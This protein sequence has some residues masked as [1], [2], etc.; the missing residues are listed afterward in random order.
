MK[1][2]NHPTAQVGAPPHHNSDSR[3]A[4]TDN[5]EEV[6]REICENNKEAHSELIPISNM[7]RLSNEWMKALF[8]LGKKICMYAKMKKV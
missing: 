5:M 4:A 6:G 2:C 7:E 3:R 1:N 8:I